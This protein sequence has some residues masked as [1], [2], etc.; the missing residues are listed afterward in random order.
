MN[1]AERK[2]EEREQAKNKKVYTMTHKQIQELEE[3]IRNDEAMR[4]KQVFI[5]VMA[6]SLNANYKFGKKRIERV[7][8]DISGQL[9]A[10]TNKT[11][12]PK[13]ILDLSLKIGVD[14]SK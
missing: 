4:T 8:N 3:R 2:R 11:V 14:Y 6:N 5:A 7:Q 13:E 12:H 1:R 9:L 10:V